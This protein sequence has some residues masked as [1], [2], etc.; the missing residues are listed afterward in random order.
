MSNFPYKVNFNNS[1][2][3]PFVQGSRNTPTHASLQGHAMGKKAK[4]SKKVVK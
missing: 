2:N 1:V 3:I 4:L